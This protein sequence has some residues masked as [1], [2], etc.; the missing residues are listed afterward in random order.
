MITMQ[1]SL[2]DMGWGQSVPT[3]HVQQHAIGTVVYAPYFDYQR[4]RWLTLEWT[5]RLYSPTNDKYLLYPLGMTRCHNWYPSAW[6]S[7][8]VRNRLPHRTLDSALEE[9]T[10]SQSV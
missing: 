8:K 7:T 1:P 3:L 2:F 9:I 10:C 5:V 6:I 4:D